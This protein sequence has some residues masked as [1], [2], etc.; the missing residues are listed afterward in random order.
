MFGWFEQ[1]LKPFPVE[2]PVAPP[3][4]LF[5]F[6][7]HYTKPAAPW[8]TAMAVLTALIAI[9]EVALFQFLGDIVDWLTNADKATFLETEWPRLAMMGALILIGLP[10][11]AGLD[12]LIMHQVL[13]G[14]YPMIARWQMHRF[15]LRHSMTF[16]ANEFA[17][18]VATKVMQTSRR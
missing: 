7:W 17:G 4:G 1:R 8:L 6:C 18:R 16:F 11:A 10:L 2:E 15:L 9:G 12:S 5:A 3:R 14:N 13:L